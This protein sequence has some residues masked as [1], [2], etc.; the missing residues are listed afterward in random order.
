MK[1]RRNVARII[2][3][4]AFILTVICFVGAVVAFFF[5]KRAMP[6]AVTCVALFLIA[7]LFAF[8]GFFTKKLADRWDEGQ[9]NT[10]GEAILDA[11]E[12]ALE[13]FQ[14]LH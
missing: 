9:R 10:P 8:V 12:T 4:I 7:I 1:K 14:F 11:A 3:V 6:W 13:F 5:S 2:S